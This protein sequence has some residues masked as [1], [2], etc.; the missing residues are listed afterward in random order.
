M[1]IPVP[2][3]EKTHDN[4][5]PRFSAPPSFGRDTLW[6]ALIA[7]ACFL[8]HNL[9]FLFRESQTAPAAVWPA[10]GIGLAALLLCPRRLWP[11]ILGV[12]FFVGSAAHLLSGRPLAVSV[13]FATAGVI[14]SL[15]CAWLI[16][17]WC[18]EN[19][20]FSRIQEVGALI[21]SA[22]VVNAGTSLLGAGTATL[23]HNGLF[24]S[25][26]QTWWISNGLGILLITPLILAW[27]N[28][29]DR[30]PRLRWGRRLESGL[31]MALWCAAGWL[32]FHPGETLHPLGAY[33][34]MLV[35]LLAW[36]ALRLGQRSVTLALVMLAAIAVTS[37]AGSVGLPLWGGESHLERLLAVQVYLAFT[38][39]TGL[40]LSASFTETLSAE[41][42]SREDQARLRALGDNLPNGM[43]YQVVRERD[44]RTR[45]LYVSGG[46][47]RL[48]GVS[49]EEVLRDPSALYR[50]VVEEDRAALAAAEEASKT[51]LSVFE[52]VVRLR[53]RDGEIRWMYLSSSPR[54]MPGGQMLWDGIQLDV[55][56][57]KRVEEALRESEER[58]KALFDRSLD[59]VFLTDFEGRF[60]D[61]NQVFLDML[62]YRREDIATLTLES[63]LSG[64]QLLL[65]RR[66]VQGIRAT[67]H[68]E[69]SNEYRAHR[70]DGKCVFVETQSA[71]IYREGQPFAIQSVGRDITERKRA[72][73]EKAKVQ[74]QLHHAQKME[75]IG[76]LAGG[77][78]HDFNN[79]LTVINGY[80][81]LGMAKLSAQ[82]PLRATLEEIRKA[83]ERAA[84]LT[85][86]LLAF[87]RKQVL[88]PRALDLNHLVEE[89]RPML[90]RLVGEDV[91]VQVTLGA[92][93]GTVHADPNQVT[94]VVMNLAV[95]AR[96]AMPGGG[97]LLIETAVVERD[98]SY[99]R[100][101]PEA[102]AGRYVMLAVSDNGTGMDEATQERI[103]EPFFTTKEAGQGTGL[104]LSMVQGIVAQSGGYIDLYSEPGQGTT[105]KVYLPAFA[106]AAPSAGMPEPVPVLGGTETVLVVE[107]QAEVRE[108]AVTVLKEYGYRVIDAETAN[109]ALRCCEWE[110]DPIH[111]LLTDVVMPKMSGRE[112]ADRLKKV[113]PGIKV[114]F[115]SGYTDDVILRHGMLEEGV[116]F[117]EK[118]FSPEKLAGKVR[119]VLGPQDFPDN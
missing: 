10:S 70:K 50:L 106:E 15:A 97:T 88:Q 54:Q 112:L 75:S 81:R 94:Q 20:S 96:D 29:Q 8:A 53:R 62:G 103:F 48:T 18:G 109:D 31:F 107:D 68:Q 58:Y 116:Q 76:R 22:T 80:S 119:A 64:D 61:A 16:S 71:L 57:R 104:G 32:A 89:M 43:V 52:V 9:V 45:F 110:R 117:I 101:H 100:L 35:A 23:I 99:A 86:Q 95:N 26:W 25:F 47:E 36:P 49:A 73:E 13:G 113:R 12:L 40:L 3:V 2:A 11:T 114:L 51:D 42:S 66:T 118:P 14:E 93:R 33:P 7:L 77:V 59:C 28:P 30:F 6:G 1:K 74:A 82:D 56:E 65:A 91:D 44:G 41:R 72:E 105:F 102:R 98:E 92:E 69:K 79:L 4:G 83:G 24:W 37:R 19:V 55:T 108:Y 78:A 5:V 63:V 67:G 87:S 39:V 90:A 21:V 46:I 111:L 27:F 84:G 60:L 38:V 17:R 34:Y 115:M 85:R